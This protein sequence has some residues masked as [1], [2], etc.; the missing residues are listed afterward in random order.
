[1]PG[2]PDHAKGCRSGCG[3]LLASSLILVT[4]LTPAISYDKAAAIAEYGH[5]HGLSLREAALTL[6]HLSGEELDRWVRPER[7]VNG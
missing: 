6:G 5:Y 4:A 3:S 7:M 1:V 2:A